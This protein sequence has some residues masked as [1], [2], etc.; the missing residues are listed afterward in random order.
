MNV[1]ALLTPAFQKQVN[2]TL[3]QIYCH[4]LKFSSF[5]L[6]RG[7]TRRVWRLQLTSVTVEPQW[8]E[9]LDVVIQFS[10][11]FGHFNLL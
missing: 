3:G 4:I 11:Y 6:T 7:Q 10:S 1:E 8:F 5:T 2:A 9:P